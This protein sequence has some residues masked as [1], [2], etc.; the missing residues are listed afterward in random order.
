MSDSKGLTMLTRVVCLGLC[1]CL[2]VLFVMK[3]TL[4][5]LNVFHLHS[6]KGFS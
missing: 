4:V 3:G 5:S 2:E 1:T 6:P